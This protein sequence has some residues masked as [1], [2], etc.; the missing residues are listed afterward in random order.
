MANRLVLGAFDGDMVLRVSRPGYNVL[1]TGLTAEQISFDSRWVS[2]GKIWT[3]GMTTNFVG[4]GDTVEVAIPLGYTPTS[5]TLPIILR[6]LKRPANIYG[7]G[8]EPN[9]GL[10]RFEGTTAYVGYVLAH[11]SQ[12]EALYYVVMRP[13]G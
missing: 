4:N 5:E 13:L 10:L 1:S 12:F 6:M 11:I 3:R 9:T 2:T 7:G 8:W